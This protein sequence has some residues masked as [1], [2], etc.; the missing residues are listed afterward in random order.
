MANTNGVIITVYVESHPTTAQSSSQSVPLINTNPVSEKPKRGQCYD[1]RA[2][3]LAYT[4]QLRAAD[5]Y[6]HPIQWNHSSPKSKKWKCPIAPR[7]LAISFLGIFRNTK[8]RWKYQRMPSEEGDKCNCSGKKNIFQR[9]KFW[10]KLKRMFKGLSF[11][12]QRKKRVNG[13]LS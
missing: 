3:L 10:S 1:R 9:R 8:R 7:R 13:K 11:V 5:K 2:R 6:H 12:W 4:Q